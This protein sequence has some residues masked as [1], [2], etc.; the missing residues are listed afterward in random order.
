MVDRFHC[1]TQDLWDAYDPDDPR[2]TYVFTLT[3]DKYIGDVMAQDNA[4]A[5]KAIT[6][7]K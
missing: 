3:G 6:T 1:P 4:M 7:I 2:L 5:L